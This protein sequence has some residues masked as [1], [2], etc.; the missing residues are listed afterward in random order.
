MLG[1][2]MRR[3]RGGR[4]PKKGAGKKKTRKGR[5]PFRFRRVLGRGGLGALVAFG[6]GYGVSTRVL[7]PVPPPPRGLVEIPDLRGLS[8]GDALALIQQEGFGAAPSVRYRHPTA[9]LGNVLGQTPL[10][11]QLALPGDTVSLT[12][13][14]GAERRPVPD[15][16]R[17]RE[18][19]ARNVLEATG[20]TVVADTL[21]SELPRGRVVE[22]VPEPG[23]DVALPMEVTMLVSTGPA[24]VRM[25]LLLGLERAEAEA[26][27]DSLGL[28]LEEVTTRFRFGR[29]QGRVVEQGPPA[30]S[31]LDPG[32][33][34]RVVVGRRAR[35]RGN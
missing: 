1:G 10:P 24:Q 2:S 13:S 20:F 29:D 16:L 11:G 12:L 6:I 27:V 33:G 14:L 31:L 26:L 34:V 17:L 15:V 25:P 30:D 7:F 23:T 35:G 3:R 32:A 21:Q 19:W 4:K 28:V 9:P 18:G 22:V 5:K 8:E